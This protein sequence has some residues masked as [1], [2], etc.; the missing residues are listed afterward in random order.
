MKKVSLDTWIQLIGMLGVLGG[1]V[2]VGLE[3]R[4]SHT[5]ALATQV[6]ARLEQLLDR[7][8]TWFEGQWELGYTLATTPYNQLTDSERWAR[9]QDLDW[10]HR[11]QQ[12][13]YYQYKIGLLSDEQ[14]SALLVYIE[15]YW[16]MCD[17][18]HVYDFPALEPAYA[19]YL[20]S[21]DDPCE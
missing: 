2:F 4:Q 11:M 8:R 20:R 19:E 7:N 14:A 18:R 12:N 16:E 5:I 17:V 10:I 13:S 21:L 15:R 9:D 6:Q 3:M 1:L